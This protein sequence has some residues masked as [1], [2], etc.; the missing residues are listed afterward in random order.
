MF[1]DKALTSFR[2]FCK[3]ANFKG[4]KDAMPSDM[5]TKRGVTK[6]E[7][8]LAISKAFGQVSRQIKLASDASINTL[9]QLLDALELA[10]DQ[11]LSDP[12]SKTIMNSPAPGGIKKNA[13]TP[14]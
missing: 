3:E 10:P 5:V 14:S 6:R 9:G 12:T 1:S 2:Q 11:E 7:L 4:V 8:D 13:G